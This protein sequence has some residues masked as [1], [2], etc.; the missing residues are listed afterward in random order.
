M[1]SLFRRIRRIIPNRAKCYEHNTIYHD[2]CQ[3]CRQARKYRKSRERCNAHG[4]KYLQSCTTCRRA[5]KRRRARLHKKIT[6]GV[7]LQLGMEVLKGLGYLAAALVFIIWT[8]NN[9]GPDVPITLQIVLAAIAA[10][11]LFEPAIAGTRLAKKWARTISLGTDDTDALWEPDWP[12]SRERRYRSAARRRQL[13]WQGA[14]IGAM[15]GLAFVAMLLTIIIANATLSSEISS[16]DF[17]ERIKDLAVHQPALTTLG[18]ITLLSFP[19]LGGMIGHHVEKTLWPK[20]DE[21]P[22]LRDDW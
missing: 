3:L 11:I 12:T 17:L 10:G 21:N 14:T 4:I 16:E 5:Y 9:F 20:P 19:V 13:R 15:I 18:I 2:D 7:T 22:M 1:Q 6:H 8:F